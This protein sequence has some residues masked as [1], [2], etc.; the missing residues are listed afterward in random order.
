MANVIRF[1]AEKTC[2]TFC[3][4]IINVPRVHPSFFYASCFFVRQNG[5]TFRFSNDGNRNCVVVT[6]QHEIENCFPLHDYASHVIIES[7]ICWSAA[8]KTSLFVH[9]QHGNVAN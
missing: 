4:I 6:R 5:E 1:D 9:T 7:W 2:R 3:H 8:E